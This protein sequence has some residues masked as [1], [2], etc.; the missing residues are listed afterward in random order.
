MDYI[1]APNPPDETRVKRLI[2][3]GL[4]FPYVKVENPDAAQKTALGILADLTD[5]R[6]IRHELDAID[7]DVKQE[8][9]DTLTMII[10]VGMAP[11]A[12]GQAQS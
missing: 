3:H 7:D 1:D 6:G 9:F 10:R 11:A 8:I 2:E 12:D 4:E 5:R